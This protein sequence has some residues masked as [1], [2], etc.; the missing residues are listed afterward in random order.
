VNLGVDQSGNRDL[1]LDRL[2]ATGRS[3]SSEDGADVIVLGCAGMTPLRA[4]LEAALGVPVIDPCSTAA[5]LA[6]AVCR[7]RGIA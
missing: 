1:A 3:L 2:I 5:S 4:D 6:F 7:E